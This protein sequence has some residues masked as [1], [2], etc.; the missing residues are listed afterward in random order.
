MKFSKYPLV[1]LVTLIFVC[2]SFCNLNA[3]QPAF[4]SAKGAGGYASGGRG[5]EVIHVTTLDWEAEGGLKQALLTTG[6][7]TIVFDVS[8][9]IDASTEPQWEYLL[10][11]SNYDNLTIAGQTAPLGGITIKTSQFF[12]HNL[13]NVIIRYIRFRRSASSGFNSS[14]LWLRGCTTPITRAIRNSAIK[15]STK[16]KPVLLRADDRWRG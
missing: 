14:A 10:D 9:E 11:G 7:R 8:G 12:I 3:Q 13:D 16:L 5:G 4:P 6:P 1:Y 15:T 2:L